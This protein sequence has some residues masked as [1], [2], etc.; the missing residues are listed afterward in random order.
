MRLRNSIATALAV[1]LIAATAAWPQEPS[2]RTVMPVPRDG[3]AWRIDKIA[4]IPAPLRTAI[5]RV[6]CELEEFVLRE[7]PIQIFQPGRA[8]IAI[9][10]CNGIIWYGRAFLFERDQSIEPKPM[11]FP[12][13]ALPSGFGTTDVP[14]VL[15]WDAST[16]TLTATQGNDVGG[17][18]ETRHTYR[19]D[20]RQTSLF[21]L[22]RVETAKCCYA[23]TDQSW[24][25]IWEARAWPAL[26]R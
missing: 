3:Q 16:K 2:R 12:T 1:V 13:L 5:D 17:G 11:L 7:M 9:V 24:S 6:H 15:A 19:Y 25:P 18:D 21:T 4:D 22:I 10:P 23:A 14:G 20:P 26:H 8:L